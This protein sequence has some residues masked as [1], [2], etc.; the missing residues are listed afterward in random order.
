MDD[1]NVSV[2]TYFIIIGIS[3]EPLVQVFLFLLVLLTYLTALGGNITIFLLVCLDHHLHT[4]MYFFLA[5]L[6][7]LDISCSTIT[8]HKTLISFISGDG[9]ISLFECYANIFAF[10]SFTC[11]ELLVLAAMSYDRYVAIC[12]PLHYYLVMNYNICVLLA[13]ICWGYGLLENLPTFWG[14]F[15]LT[16]YESN[17]VDHFFCDIVPILKLTCSDKSFL[18]LYFLTAGVFSGTFTPFALTFISY[19]F[20]ISTILSIRSSSGRRKAFFTCFSHL[21]VVITLYASLVFQYLRPNASI[22]LS[23][24]KYFSLFNAAAVPILNP[25]IY[26]LKNK[27]VKAAIRRRISCR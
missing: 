27:D 2:P 21:T 5:N 1:R 14:L 3:D 4:P 18:Q 23:S 10:F 11:I 16:C 15:K 25:L 26:S 13:C 7:I 9:T 22:N 20:I 17:E 6:S 12:N 19:I 8:L 24:N